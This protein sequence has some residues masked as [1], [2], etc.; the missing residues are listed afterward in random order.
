MKIKNV[1]GLQAFS[2]VHLIPSLV[3]DIKGIV[4]QLLTDVSGQLICL[5]FKDRVLFF[6][7]GHALFFLESFTFKNGTDRFSR[8]VDK[9]LST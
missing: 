8:N 1:A 4:S 5:T 7:E 2:S 3:W 6:L 9:Q